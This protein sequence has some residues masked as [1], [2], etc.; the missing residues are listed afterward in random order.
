[1]IGLFLGCDFLSSSGTSCNPL[2]S[3]FLCL[4]N[5]YIVHISPMSVTKNKKFRFL[6]FFSLDDGQMMLLEIFVSSL[7]YVLEMVFHLFSK[8]HHFGTVTIS[9]KTYFKNKVFWACLVNMKV[10]MSFLWV[11]QHQHIITYHH[12][13]SEKSSKNLTIW[14]NVGKIKSFW[15]KSRSFHYILSIT[16]D[17][18]SFS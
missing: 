3:W 16:H 11:F 10:E 9:D 5:E 17:I 14:L 12:P 4:Q 8:R 15:G 1:M 6:V 18:L 2:E 7:C 13:F